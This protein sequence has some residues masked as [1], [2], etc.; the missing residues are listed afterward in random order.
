MGPTGTGTSCQR[1]GDTPDT[2]PRAPWATDMVD[3]WHPT[4]SAGRLAEC[5]VAEPPHLLGANER[6]GGIG[7]DR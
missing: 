3:F 4:G 5:V 7:P 2:S 6:I 1:L